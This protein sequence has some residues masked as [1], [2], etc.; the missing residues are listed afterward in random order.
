MCVWERE[1]ERERE[2]VILSNEPVRVLSNGVHTISTRWLDSCARRSVSPHFNTTI[3]WTRLVSRC[4]CPSGRARQV[5][6]EFIR[7]RQLFYYVETVSC[8]V[9]GWSGVDEWLACLTRQCLVTDTA[10]TSRCRLDINVV[11]VVSVDRRSLTEDSDST[12]VQWLH[13]KSSMC[14]LLSSLFR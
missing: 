4:F 10:D 6:D 14:M 12:R 3:V 5:L 2:R 13:R 8:Q 1:R 9:C 11:V 7:G